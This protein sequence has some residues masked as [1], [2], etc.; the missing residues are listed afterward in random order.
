MNHI[1][2]TVDDLAELMGVSRS[3]IYSLKRRDSWPHLL[4]GSKVRFNDENLIDIL[5]LYAKTPTQPNQ[6]PRI[7]TRSKRTK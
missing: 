5:K 1:L 3:Q 7:G 2:Y 4:I 6:R